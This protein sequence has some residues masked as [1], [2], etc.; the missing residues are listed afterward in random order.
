[1]DNPT[2]PKCSKRMD[3]GFTLDQSYSSN[4]QAEWVEGQPRRSFWTGGG[5]KLP[6]A[7]PHPI[8]TY[9]C[10]GCGYLES[11]APIA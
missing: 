9:R 7:A 10:S 6:A 1:M 4:L 8:T 2:C 11:Y 5:V 3:E